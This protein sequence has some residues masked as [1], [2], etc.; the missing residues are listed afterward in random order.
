MQS[1]T[2]PKKNSKFWT[3]LVPGGHNFD[4]NE[5]L[6]EIISYSFFREPLKVFF[7]SFILRPIGVPPP[8]QYLVENLECQWGAG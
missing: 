6:T 1:L 4:L 2:I 8:P 5:N 7:L 3:F